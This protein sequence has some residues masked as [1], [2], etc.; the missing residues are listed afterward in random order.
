[1]LQ[2]RDYARV[3][4]FSPMAKRRA[5]VQSSDST[6]ILA[7]WTPRGPR[8]SCWWNTHDQ[9]IPKKLWFDWHETGPRCLSHKALQFVRLW[10][11]WNWEKQNTEIV[12][13]KRMIV[14][15]ER[16]GR[17][18]GLTYM[19]IPGS[20]AG[21]FIVFY[22]VL[23]ILSHAVRWAIMMPTSWVWAQQNCKLGT[24]SV[25]CVSSSKEYREET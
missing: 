24:V 12:E 17:A 22:Y 2:E 9:A 25:V 13:V 1:M 18:W 20:A 3:D 5:H 19:L 4:S 6:P 16:R 8:E 10:M 23:G 7:W 21:C 15:R 11:L 14:T